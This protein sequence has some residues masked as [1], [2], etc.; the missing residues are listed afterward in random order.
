MATA[1]G[2]FQVYT[3]GS[4][5]MDGRTFVKILKDTAILDGKTLTTVDADLI[6]TKVKA[7]GA[8]KID[9]AQFEEALKLVGEKKKVSTEQIVSKLASGETGPILT[10]TKA[11]NVRFHDDKNTYTG[12]HK[13]G[14][15]TLV[16]EGRTQF[17]DL[18]N[19]CDRSDYDVRG[20][21]KGVAE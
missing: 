11:D 9:Y 8:K 7:K 2:A 21:K 6:F 10:G 14:G 13:H 4:G 5:D 15:P 12:V 17:S 19:I 16:D 1:S 3:K 20:V 18:S